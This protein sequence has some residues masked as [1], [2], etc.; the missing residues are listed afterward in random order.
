MIDDAEDAYD[1][2]AA[3]VGLSLDMI[4][5]EIEA[6]LPMHAGRLA[7]AWLNEEYFNCRN[8]SFIPRRES[9]D[10]RDYFR[11]PKRTSKITRKV[12]RELSKDLYNPGPTRKLENGAQEDA[13]LQGVYRTNH[14]NALLQNAERKAALNGA[15]AIQAVATGRAEKPIQLHLWGAHETVV[16]PW[17]DDPTEPW[18]V[19]TIQI[20]R[21]VVG[22]GRTEER[23]HYE[24]WSRDEHRVYLSTWTPVT[25][26]QRTP[27]FGLS[28]F[29]NLF[30]VAAE[31]M[32]MMSGLP[33]GSGVNPYG[34]IPFEFVH[35]EPVVSDFWEGGIGNPLREAN[36]E[37]DRELSELAEH[38]REFMNPDRFLRNVNVKFR[39]EKVL[40]R[41]Q[42]LTPAM[43]AEGD[44]AQ[45]PDAFLVQGRLAVDD[46]WSNIMRYANTTL[47]ELDVPLV[48]VR[49]DASTDLSGVAVVAK[50]LPML[51]RTRSRQ[52]PATETEE[53][54]AGMTLTAA[55]NFYGEPRL[56]KAG[57]QPKLNCLW[58]EPKMPLP[59]PERDAEDAADVESGRKSV[60]RIV[61]E[62][63]GVTLEQAREILEQ[64]ID[65][66]AW[67]ADLLKKKGVAPP[68]PAANEPAAKTG[69]TETPPAEPAAGEPDDTTTED[70]EQQ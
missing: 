32:P 2:N 34:V 13:W 36:A 33:A 35:A 27:G 46:V 44:A 38:T 42:P 26:D 57:M 11:R 37:I 66:N 62:R 50:Q 16:W 22:G 6:G 49:D 52:A 28:C 30:G 8:A 5:G 64:V 69:E 61:A 19:C 15:A 58:P 47:E 7:Q 1:E 3:D 43:N 31:Y 41:W 56:L 25:G 39:R 29:T 40:G 21:Q 23:L 48:A 54:V 18:A 65:E 4:E 20:E 53:R 63:N 14:V 51:S 12:V 10:W 24:V 45:Q 55:G 68:E 60:V 17:P 9:E 59:T 70:D 67:Y